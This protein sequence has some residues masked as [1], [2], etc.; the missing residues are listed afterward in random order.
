MQW[1]KYIPFA[2]MAG[3]AIVGLVQRYLDERRCPMPLDVSDQDVERQARSG[4]R[5]RA[6][7]WYRTLHGSSLKE[8]SRA[9]DRMISQGAQD[10]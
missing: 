9:V 7:R 2:V 10:V 8:A 6:I 3:F 1:A 5:T 4:A